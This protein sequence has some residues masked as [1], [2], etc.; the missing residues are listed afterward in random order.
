MPTQSTDFIGNPYGISY[1]AA[2]QTWTILKGVD[3]EGAVIGVLSP[4]ADSILNNRGSVIGGSGGVYFDAGGLTSSYVVRNQKSGDIEGTT[5]AVGLT[6]F[7]GSALIENR[8]H[9]ASDLYALYA[10][11][12]QASVRVVNA[13]SIEG[14]SAGMFFQ[15]A[16]AAE[17][18]NTGNIYGG[19]AGI[20]LSLEPGTS[21]SRIE[22]DGKIVSAQFAIYAL[23]ATGAGVEIINHKGAVIESQNVA[24]GI[25]ERLTLRNEGKID[26]TTISGGFGDTVVNKG[27]MGDVLLSD[28]ADVFRSKGGKAKAGLIDAG[29]GNDLVVLGHKADKL[30]FDTF[31]NAATNVDTIRK[32]DSGKD[33]FYLDE[34]IFT[35]ITPGTLSATE[36][37]KGTAATDADQRIIY[38]RKS[39]ALYYDSDGTGVFAQTQFAQFDAG[40]KLK[41]SDFTIGEYSIV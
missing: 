15:G 18:E 5:I 41:A 34:D 3:L 16:F 33:A 38:D 24:V 26:G 4:F 9:I 23:S 39:G 12:G 7:T 40:T 37:H 6:D 25:A 30:L 8:G 1:T 20:A 32:F 27:K 17:V 22:N 19:D 14:G 10:F 11:D 31:L 21:G 35:T 36:F 29:D 28:G 13:G 2:A